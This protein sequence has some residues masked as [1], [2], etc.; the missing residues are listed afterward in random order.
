MYHCIFVDRCLAQHLFEVISILMYNLI[1][2]LN[3]LMN[4]GH[5]AYLLR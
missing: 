4:H 5:T 2:G 3:S 1:H